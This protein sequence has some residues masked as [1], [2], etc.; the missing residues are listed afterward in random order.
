MENKTKEKKFVQREYKIRR[1]SKGNDTYN[2]LGWKQKMDKKEGKFF[3][4][5]TKREELR[6]RW[7][8]FSFEKKKKVTTRNQKN[9]EETLKKER[10]LFSKND[11][12]SM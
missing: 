1:K 8:Y 11:I 9:E 3:S 10:F 12:K 7:L 2:F 5:K 4:K 6:H